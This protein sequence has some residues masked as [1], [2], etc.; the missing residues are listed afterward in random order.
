[1]ILSGQ[2]FSSKTDFLRWID[3]NTHTEKCAV[4]DKP[5]LVIPFGRKRITCSR[6]CA[7]AYREEEKMRGNQI[8]VTCGRKITSVQKGFVDRR[9]RRYANVPQWLRDQ[10]AEQAAAMNPQSESPPDENCGI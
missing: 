1:M 5:I 9:R 8:C 7:V 10:E 6:A 3:E 4:C 2:T